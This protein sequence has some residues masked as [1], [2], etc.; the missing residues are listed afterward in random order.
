MEYGSAIEYKM[1]FTLG[2]GLQPSKQKGVGVR[3]GVDDVDRC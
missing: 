3:D 1:R 2:I